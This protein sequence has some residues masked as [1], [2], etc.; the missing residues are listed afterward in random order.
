MRIAF[1]P[2]SDPSAELD[3]TDAV[4]TA[5]AHQLGRA[6]GGNDAL[7]RLEAEHQLARLLSSSGTPG[8]P[9]GG[10]R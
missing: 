1:R 6:L 7:N 9:E 5:V 10:P 8:A 4:V 3:V 2:I